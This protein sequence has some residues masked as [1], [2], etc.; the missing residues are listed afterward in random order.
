MTRIKIL[1]KIFLYLY[2]IKRSWIFLVGILK[3]KKKSGLGLDLIILILNFEKY[4]LREKFLK[5][6]IFSDYRKITLTLPSKQH[7][8]PLIKGTKNP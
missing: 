6:A 2:W 4:W 8:A 3:K 5:I 1:Y 7:P